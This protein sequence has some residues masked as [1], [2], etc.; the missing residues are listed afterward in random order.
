M[1]FIE[2]FRDDFEYPK[3]SILDTYAKDFVRSLN[4]L[5]FILMALDVEHEVITAIEEYG[6]DVQITDYDPRNPISFD[7]YIKTDN[8]VGYFE[9]NMCFY[10]LKGVYQGYGVWE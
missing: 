5:S 1:G 7:T 6:E 3:D 10:F 9:F 8:G 2:H 4:G